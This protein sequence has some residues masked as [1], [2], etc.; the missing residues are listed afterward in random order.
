MHA[1]KQNY[2][3]FSSV[4]RFLLH[5]HKSLHELSTQWQD[6]VIQL[7]VK[8]KKRVC[9][10]KDRGVHLFAKLNEHNEVVI[11]TS[12][13][14][15]VLKGYGTRIN[16]NNHDIVMSRIGNRQYRDITGNMD[17]ANVNDNYIERN[18]NN[19]DV[20][21]LMDDIMY[22]DLD[23]NDFEPINSSV[24]QHQQTQ[25]TRIIQ[26]VNDGVR[27]MNECIKDDMVNN[28][29]EAP[30]FD[31]K[32]KDISS[33]NKLY[34]NYK[35]ELKEM[36]AKMNKFKINKIKKIILLLKKELLNMDCIDSV[37]TL[38]IFGNNDK[39]HYIFDIWLIKN[40]KKINM[41]SEILLELI[42]LA[43]SDECNWNLFISNMVLI[44]GLFNNN[45]KKIY[46][47]L[48]EHLKK[49]DINNEMSIDKYIGN[50]NKKETIVNI[51][52]DSNINDVKCGLCN[53]TAQHPCPC[54]ELSDHGLC[55]VHEADGNQCCL[56]KVGYCN[57]DDNIVENGKDEINEY[58]NDSDLMIMDDFPKTFG[59]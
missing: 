41:G 34:D 6:F 47:Y 15:Q 46:L 5:K 22:S 17:F 25:P 40:V 57:G 48:L 50:M 43:K 39:S 11:P 52:E 10:V 33:M 19:N 45:F 23:G 58:E 38:H 26:N 20:N 59:N 1:E 51:M 42:S 3:R 49:Y 56:V 13:E 31:V 14:I 54:G 53:C 30:L 36:E 55:D 21:L 9:V 29:N 37:L 12:E 32:K 4:K 7:M 44:I 2:R 8:E 18:I 35:K 24:M 16:M 28:L 27:V